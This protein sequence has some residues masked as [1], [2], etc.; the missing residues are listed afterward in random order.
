MDALPTKS[1]IL[2]V[3]VLD[4]VAP[5]ETGSTQCIA[6]T[7]ADR[8]LSLIKPHGSAFSIAHSYAIHQDSPILDVLAING[9][10]LFVG[11]MSGK[12]LLHDMASDRNLDERKDHSKYLVKLASWSSGDSVFIASA[13]WDA[14]VV[15]YRLDHTNS[16]SAKL[17]EPIATLNLPSI[18]ETILFVQA[19]DTTQ[20]VLL[21]TRRDSTF[22]YYYALHTSSET[23][24]QLL[25]LGKQNLAPHSNAWIAFSPSDVQLCPT[26]PSTVAVATSSTPHMKLL[27]VR[28][29]VPPSSAPAIDAGAEASADL[30]SSDNVTQASQAR[31]ALALQD[32]EESAIVINVTTMAPQTNYVRKSSLQGVS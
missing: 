5:G 32:K 11:S 3:H 23:Q 25:L 13:G 30:V 28:L 24:S 20:P 31:A 21:L 8:R 6:A 2:S 22:L 12:L 9:Q 4:L 7:T 15:V 26:D 19:P 1:N 17:G 10:Y 16:R 14:K 27:V 29:L 18:P